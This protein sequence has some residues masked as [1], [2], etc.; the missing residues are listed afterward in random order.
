MKKVFTLALVMAI[1][2]SG[3]A[4]VKSA[5]PNAKDLKTEQVKVLKGFEEYNNN[6]PASTRSIMTLTPEMTELSFTSYDWQ[7]NMAAR[8]FTAVWPDGYA[9]MCFTQATEQGF[10]DRGT[11]LAIWD[12]AVGEWEYTDAR[13]EGVKTGFGSIARYKENGLVVAAHTS[14]DCR[15]FIVED[16]R[17]GNRD[18]GE[19]IVMP[20]TG[21]DGRTYDP[22]WPIVQCSGENLDVIHIMTT[23]YTLTDPYSNALLYSRYVNGEFTVVHRILPNLDG[24]HI[25]DGG[26]NITYFLA[27]NP[28]RPNRVSFVLNN[29]WS[30]GK[31]CVS[32]D[33]G[34]TWTDRVF[35]QHPGI[36]V[37]YEDSYFY[38]RWV[39]AEYDAND[40]INLVY[41]WNGTTGEPG[42]G[43]Y[44]PGL[45][46][47][48]FWSETL[49]KNELC[50][51]G[52]GNVGEPFIMDTAYLN[53]DLY[54]SEWYWSDALHDPL[55]EYF[56]ELQILDA[57]TF[58]VVPYYGEL[59][60]EYLWVDLEKR[61][62]HGSYNG[63]IAEFPSMHREGNT[64]YAFW[65]MIAGDSESIYFDDQSSSHYLRLFGAVSFD[66]GLTWEHPEHLLT[67]FEYNFNEMVYGQVIPYVYHD[68]DGDYMWYCFQTDC[69]PGT[70]VQGDETVWEDNYYYA[71][72]IYVD[73]LDVEE[74][75][76][77][78]AN[79]MEVYPNP[80]QGSFKV[81]L[82]N[83]SNVNIYN[84]VGQL[85]KSFNNVKEV[86][87]NLEAGVY[88]VNANNQTKKVVVK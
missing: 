71:L 15:I 66:G 39:C 47:I 53:S 35:Y 21:E 77:T 62:D 45:G 10:G 19:G 68:A 26:S 80:A 57:E 52:I 60:E 28:E 20:T 17:Q 16:F 55:P 25:S 83:E 30:D 88:F 1:A 78:V 6:F 76:F 24:D 23:E 41:E 87:V 3:F 56:G 5:R 84:T 44:Y 67:D 14:N 79:T 8:N 50:I 4:Q 11:G 46:G 85:V 64:I 18:F 13:V 72:K 37:T 61:S 36:N 82:N 27:Y 54:Y 75:N 9:V 73:Y 40:N 31:V 38:P 70:F 32:E 43:S 74:N 58:Q 42:S 34:D 69:Q 59:P 22:C 86:N 63:G 29:A 2:I 81:T 65:S 51:G 49:P 33:G 48:G 12:P 7:S